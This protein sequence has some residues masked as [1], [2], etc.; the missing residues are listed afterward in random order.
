M[1]LI[2]LTRLGSDLKWENKIQW[3]MQNSHKLGK[4]LKNAIPN[5]MRDWQIW[6]SRKNANQEK[7]VNLDKLEI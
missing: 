4:S 2:P 7:N 6:K 1:S 3:K 5:K